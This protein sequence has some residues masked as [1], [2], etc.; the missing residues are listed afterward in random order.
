MRRAL[1]GSNSLG[2]RALS[3]MKAAFLLD[4]L[5]NYKEFIILL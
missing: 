2:T 3:R 1:K 5:N 4:W